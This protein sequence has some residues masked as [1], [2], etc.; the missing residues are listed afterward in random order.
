LWNPKYS[1]FENLYELNGILNKLN[2]EIHTLENFIPTENK[3]IYNK[4]RTPEIWTINH[5]DELGYDILPFRHYHSYE[6]ADLILDSYIL[7]KTLLE[8]FR[9]NDNPTCWDTCGHVRTNGG[10][11]MLLGNGRQELYNSDAFN[12]WL[13]DYGI[14]K[15]QS[16]ADFPL[17]NFVS[18]HKNKL[19]SLQSELYKY[20]CQV[21]IQL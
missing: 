10:A 21:E 15:E 16:M 11:C 6:P 13:A 17:G 20:Y 19:I 12:K 1:D 5:G 14:T 7:G 9:C 18:G 3:L 2:E 4:I 8:S